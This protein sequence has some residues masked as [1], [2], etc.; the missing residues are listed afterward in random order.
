MSD[1]VGSGTWR[2]VPGTDPNPDRV[3]VGAPD[4]SEFAED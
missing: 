1:F 4:I 3:I 2:N